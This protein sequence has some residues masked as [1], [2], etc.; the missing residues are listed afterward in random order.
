ML[1]LL[2]IEYL[3]VKNYT[4]FWVIWLLY[5]AIVPL[6]YLGVCDLISR[7]IPSP[8]GPEFSEYLSFPDVWQNVVYTASYLNLLLGVLVVVLTTNEIIFKTQRQHAIEGVSRRNLILSKMLFFTFLAACV[9]LYTLIVGAVFG[10]I[11]SDFADFF[12]GIS[13]IPLYFIQTV[14]YF[15]MAF[16]LAVLIQRTALTI[17][18]FILMLF[19]NFFFVSEM[20]GEVIASYLPVSVISG[21]TQLPYRDEIYAMRVQSG[22][23]A[24]IPESL[25]QWIRTLI[26]IAYII[27]IGIVGYLVLKKRDL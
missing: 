15:A 17:V 4:T 14:G 13:S 6:I 23:L 27:L 9:S 7:M 26:A 22:E 20:V 10:F 18:V 2:K 16:L 11:Y 3:K 24:S 25:A 12:S 1:H 21:L 8:I 5:A 19:V